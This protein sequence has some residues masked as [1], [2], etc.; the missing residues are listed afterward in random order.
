MVGRHATSLV[1]ALWSRSL[2]VDITR[3]RTG[4][5]GWTVRSIMPGLNETDRREVEIC[6]PST[7]RLTGA[8]A[9]HRSGVEHANIHV[10]CKYVYDVVVQKVHVR[11]LIS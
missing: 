5:E 7:D 8:I 9:G 4:D 2:H 11:Y 6:D 1:V 10:F 3:W